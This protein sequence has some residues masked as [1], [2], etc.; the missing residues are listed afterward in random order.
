MRRVSDI[1]RHGSWLIAGGK[2][3][4]LA[5]QHELVEDQHG[6]TTLSEKL[7]MAK[8]ELREP[9]LRETQA[10]ATSGGAG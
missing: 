4:S 7:L 3:W 10:K 5:S 2:P 6:L 9:K 1:A 8:Q